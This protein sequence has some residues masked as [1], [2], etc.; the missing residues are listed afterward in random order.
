M[1]RDP[2]VR[3]PLGEWA[4]VFQSDD[5]RTPV[6]T[7]SAVYFVYGPPNQA[8]I[9]ICPLEQVPDASGERA[10][11]AV[12][13]ICPECATRGRI[14]SRKPFRI[15]DNRL[16]FRTENGPVPLSPLLT[17]ESPVEC[18][19][20]YDVLDTDTNRHDHARCTF[21]AVIRDGVAYP[22][23][24]MQVILTRA[25][26]IANARYNQAAQLFPTAG[27][28]LQQSVREQ[29]QRDLNIIVSRVLPVVCPV[30]ESGKYERGGEKS[31]VGCWEALDRIRL[32]C[33]QM[34][35]AMGGRV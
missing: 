13:F 34:V 23:A 33:E 22:M 30:V 25:L 18:A 29:A 35:T 26:Q 15:V 11:R 4:D 14:D 10:V 6:T 7:D 3:S 17:V 20:E 21:S 28:R 32:A 19:A 2:E 9:M 31:L 16:M 24:Q 5:A 12:I 1:A 8:K 27:G